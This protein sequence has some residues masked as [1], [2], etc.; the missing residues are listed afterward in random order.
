[1]HR[2]HPH[3]NCVGTT[4]AAAPTPASAFPTHLT[5]RTSRT[6]AAPAG[7][8]SPSPRPLPTPDGCRIATRGA[9]TRPAAACS[10]SKAGTASGRG[11]T[12]PG[13]M[14]VTRGVPAST[15]TISGCSSPTRWT[16]RTGSQP[17]WP[18]WPTSRTRRRSWPPAGW[19]ARSRCG[20]NPMTTDTSAMASDRPRAGAGW[21]P[22]RW[23]ECSTRCGHTAW[24]ECCFPHHR[25][26]V[27]EDRDLDSH[28]I[29]SLTAA[30]HAE[31]PPQD[32]ERQGPHHHAGHPARPPRYPRHGHALMLHPNNSYRVGL[33]ADSGPVAAGG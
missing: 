9:P 14:R 11:R 26:L 15:R 32:E 18:G 22:G 4:P 12:T 19:S 10:T 16:H 1:M 8:T 29:G 7:D 28:R 13:S 31:D 30:D 3:P 20:T 24:T 27:M 23:A 6:R 21:P 33:G 2:L 25:E 17:G 5:A